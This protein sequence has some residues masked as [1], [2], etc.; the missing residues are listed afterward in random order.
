MAYLSFISD[1]DLQ[2]E[3]R[4]L[5]EIATN[6]KIK[7]EKDFTRNVIDPFSVLF[8]MS[9]FDV[10]EVTWE[11]GEKN[12][13]IQKSLQNHVG[14]FHQRIMGWVPGWRNTGAGG[15]ID[16]VNP[17]Q[18]IIAEVKNK[19]NTVK[20]SDK[21]TIYDEFE[22]QVMTKGHQFKGYTAYCVEIIPKNRQRYDKEFVPSDKN[23]GEQRRPNPLIRQIDGY[24]FYGLV[25]GIPDALHQLFTVLPDVIEENSDF[26]F[27]NRKFSLDF[28]HK[29]FGI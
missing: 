17:Q 16:L 20:G 3:V 12:R 19:Y 22:L 10:D 5:L 11:K 18:K 8:E 27:K 9:G 1:Q 6:A 15:V 21:V 25:T 13:Q 7:S 4:R 29:A 2:R 14:E 24:S 23:R 28:F 26:K